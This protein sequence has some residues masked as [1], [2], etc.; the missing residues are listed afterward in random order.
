MSPQNR[1]CLLSSDLKGHRSPA[2]I[3][4]GCPGKGKGDRALPSTEIC[5]SQYTPICP[6][7]RS[8]IR[9][10]NVAYLTPAGHK[11]PLTMERYKG[12]TAETSPASPGHIGPMGAGNGRRGQPSVLFQKQGDGG[13]MCTRVP[14]ISGE[15][16]ACTTHR[17][18]RALRE[19]TTL[20]APGPPVHVGTTHTSASFSFLKL[21]LS[22]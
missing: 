16:G 8:H 7:K 9:Q 21:T 2:C 4:S 3:F 12:S 19:L 17:P 6:G 14:L 13:D 5:I 18:F 20:G 10:Y 1:H 15:W 22:L 11:T